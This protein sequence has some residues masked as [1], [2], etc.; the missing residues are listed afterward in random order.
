LLAD[1]TKV[2]LATTAEFEFV[3]ADLIIWADF[4]I[5]I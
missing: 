4:G 3:W 2:A 5:R 1:F